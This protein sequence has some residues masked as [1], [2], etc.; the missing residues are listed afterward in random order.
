MRQ[1][2]VGPRLVLGY[3]FVHVYRWGTSGVAVFNHTGARWDDRQVGITPDRT[4]T[5]E[6]SLVII[7][8]I[9]VGQNGVNWGK[10]GRGRSLHGGHKANV[11]P[12]LCR[13]LYR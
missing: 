4:Q 12:A 10:D 1:V 11:P 3:V 2:C 5:V 6:S 9:G 7:S 8:D 13:W